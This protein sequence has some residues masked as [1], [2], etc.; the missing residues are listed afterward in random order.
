MVQAQKI[1]QLPVP[2]TQREG[3]VEEITE[4][5]EEYIEVRDQRMELGRKEVDLRDQLL[6]MLDEHGVEEYADD[7]AGITV[8]VDVTRKVKARRKKD[9]D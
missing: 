1:D 8:T 5:A 4:L 6:D 2:G 7:D 9:E 3:V